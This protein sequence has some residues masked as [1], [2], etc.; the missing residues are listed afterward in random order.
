MLET[1]LVILT[2]CVSIGAIAIALQLVV[3]GIELLFGEDD[4]T[5]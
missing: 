3:K 2:V 1:T 5:E 4:G